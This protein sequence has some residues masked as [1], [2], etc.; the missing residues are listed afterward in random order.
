MSKE[1]IFKGD[2]STEKLE[3]LK[4]ILDEKINL[5]RYESM[6]EQGNGKLQLFYKG[7]N[8][9]VIN[10]NNTEIVNDIKNVLDYL[11]SKKEQ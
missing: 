10:S 6:M 7:T 3:S 4:E 5:S 11:S 8:A 9:E 2:V 1:L